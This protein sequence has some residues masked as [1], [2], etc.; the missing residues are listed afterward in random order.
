MQIGG[1]SVLSAHLNSGRETRDS[2]NGMQK[3][4]EASLQ[5]SVN[6]STIF[7]STKRN[8]KGQV[9]VCSDEEEPSTDK[10]SS[11]T[12]SDVPV[13]FSLGTLSCAMV[14][15]GALGAIAAFVLLRP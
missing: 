14:G 13:Q 11:W 15:S 3:V 10:P 6:C 1:Y 12:G 2:V 7:E 5:P 8:V 4:T 9:A